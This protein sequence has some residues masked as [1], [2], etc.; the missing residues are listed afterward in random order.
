MEEE[1]LGLER[2]ERNLIVLRSLRSTGSLLHNLIARRNINELLVLTSYLTQAVDFNWHHLSCI[3]MFR[4]HAF[5]NLSNS[6][7]VSF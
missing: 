1:K 2:T 7:I 5:F 3:P 4:S 6:N